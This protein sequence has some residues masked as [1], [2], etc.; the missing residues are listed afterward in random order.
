M[1]NLDECRILVTS[2]DELAKE[3]WLELSRENQSEAIV[4]K[5]LRDIKLHLNYLHEAALNKSIHL[6]IDY[7]KWNKSVLTHLGFEGTNV[8]EV[9]T[10]MATVL[11]H[12]VPLTCWNKIL[13]SLKAGEKAAQEPVINSTHALTEDNPHYEVAQKYL[14]LLLNANRSDATNLILNRVGKDLSVED[15]YLQVFEP[16]L[17]EVGLLWQYNKISVAQEHFCTAATQLIMSMLYPQIFSTT[18]NKGNFLGV[19]VGTELHELGIRMVTDFMEMNGWE[20]YYIGANTP[21]STIT[22]SIKNFKPDVIGISA[23]MTYHIHY[24]TELITEINDEFGA[25][26]PKIIV[27]GY[28]FIVDENLWEIVGADAFATNANDAVKEALKLY[29]K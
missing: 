14:K 28:P 18:K 1:Q 5:S 24:V 16:V 15:T 25:Q 29:K 20:T 6:F 23:T 9:I 2:A 21:I 3:T 17:K 12:K 7:V 11:A 13:P 10:A 22:S 19:A 27:G 4:N 8:S 26:K